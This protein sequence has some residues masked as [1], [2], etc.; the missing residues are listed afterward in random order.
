MAEMVTTMMP[1]AMMDFLMNGR[2]QAAIGNRD[3]SMAPHGVFPTAGDDKWIAIA[4]ATDDEFAKLC[5]ALGVP[6]MSSDPKFARLL[7]RLDHV[8][9]LEREIAAR[10][11]AHQRDELVTKLRERGLAAGPVYNTP[12]V[13]NDPVFS[14]SGMLVN[15]KHGEVGERVVPGLPVR[16]S[17]IDLEYRG[18]PMIGEHTDEVMRE[19]GYSTAEIAR[20]KEAKVLI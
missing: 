7:G 1:E 3:E 18:A 10:T 19:F 16:F 8:D 9:E 11:R 17:A 6:S 2:D 12:E 13:I 5:E 15:L 20:L 14:Q 4:I